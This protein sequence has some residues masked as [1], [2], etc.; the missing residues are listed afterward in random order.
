MSVPGHAADLPISS[1][2]RLI[3]RRHRQKCSTRLRE[4]CAL[5]T[6]DGVKSDACLDF[7]FPESFRWTLNLWWLTPQSLI[8]TLLTA[9]DQ[10]PQSARA[11][12][13]P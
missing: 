7:R 4:R 8:L 10:R 12:Q 6:H 1:L 13:A 2:A 5:P 11:A 3:F 9:L